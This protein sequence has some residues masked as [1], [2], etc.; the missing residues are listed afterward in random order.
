MSTI[1]TINTSLFITPVAHRKIRG[2]STCNDFKFIYNIQ[3]LATVLVNICGLLKGNWLDFILST[4]LK[5][6]S[7][8]KITN[9][10]LD[11]YFF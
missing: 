1:H 5:H 10:R 9:V 3:I 6:Y 11:L 7:G 8:I 4:P 2:D